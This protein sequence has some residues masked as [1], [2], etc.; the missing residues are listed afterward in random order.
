MTRKVLNFIGL[1]APE[2]MNSALARAASSSWWMLQ[3]ETS[4]PALAT[5]MI[6]SLKSSSPKPMARSIARLGARSGPEVISLDGGGIGGLHDSTLAHPEVRQARRRAFA[7]PQSGQ[8][9]GRGVPEAGGQGLASD[10]P[11]STARSARRPA[12]TSLASRSTSTLSEG[13]AST[14]SCS[15][16]A[17]SAETR[18]AGRP[19][20]TQLPAKISA[21][22]SPTSAVMPAR[23]RACGAC[24]REEPQPKLRLTTRI[25]AP[26]R[27][28]SR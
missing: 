10:S 2:A 4:A 14:R 22:D 9:L 13:S 28:A 5:P 16:R 1:A 18:A 26:C 19:S 7:W 15:A 6:G 23:A 25:D 3:G 20:E 12:L 17:S 21:K 8:E 24:S 27:T 11:A